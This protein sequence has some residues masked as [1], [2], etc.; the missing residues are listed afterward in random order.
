MSKTRKNVAGKNASN[1]FDFA[2]QE[3]KRQ[4]Y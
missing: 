1:C 3:Q 2:Q 4:F